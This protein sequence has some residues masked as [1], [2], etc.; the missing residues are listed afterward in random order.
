MAKTGYFIL[1]P[2]MPLHWKICAGVFILIVFTRL[3]LWK[4]KDDDDD[5]GTKQISTHV[6]LLS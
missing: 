1:S 5:D 3:G 6:L 4:R 2:V